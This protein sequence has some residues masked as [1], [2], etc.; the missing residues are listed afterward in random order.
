M[1]ENVQAVRF[2]DELSS[3]RNRPWL[4]EA[5]RSDG[6]VVEV[7]AKLGSA[8]C[9]LGGLVREAYGAMLGSDLDLPVS[10]S[11]V[12]ELS[13]DFLGTLRPELRAKV[14]EH[15]LAFGSKFIPSML[16]VQSHT[17]LPTDLLQQAAEALTFDAG[18]VN[19]DRLV[20]KPN[21]LTDG[22]SLL[23][24]DHELSLNLQGR[25]FLM[26]DPWLPG[27]LDLMTRPPAEHL[28]YR[29]LKPTRS[30]SPRP[31]F[32]GI[33]NKLAAIEASRIAEYREAI[34]PQWDVDAVSN[35]IAAFL[36][37]LVANA[38]SLKNEVEGI[39]S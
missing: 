2:V 21:C 32:G 29:T 24:I 22:R 1:L 27:A 20:R 16:S 13:A 36:V 26:Q 31:Q 12:V 5:E 30:D 10:E 33:C 9:G 6:E 37:E 39:L 17:V 11:F 7:V 3:G 14:G 28:F 35:D 4:L 23:L 25:G 8:E 38:H 34:P 18:I 15:P 19:S